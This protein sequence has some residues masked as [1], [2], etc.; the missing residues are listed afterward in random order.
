ME[1]LK[2]HLLLSGTL[3]CVVI[4]LTALSLACN[5]FSVEVSSQVYHVSLKSVS[6]Y[7]Q[8]GDSSPLVS[9][10]FGE[11]Q[12]KMCAEDTEE[13]C[14][15][16]ASFENAGVIYL[17]FCGFAG[18]CLVAGLLHTVLVYSV[19][20]KPFRHLSYFHFTPAPLYIFGVVLYLT[21]SKV[22]STPNSLTEA[23]LKIAYFLLPVTVLEFL[24]VLYVKK[25]KNWNFG[26]LK[27]ETIDEVKKPSE[28]YIEYSLDTEKFPEETNKQLKDLQE[29]LKEETKTSEQLRLELINK[30]KE[31]EESNKQLE[32]AQSSQKVITELKETQTKLQ[33]EL[34]DNKVTAGEV[35]KLKREIEQKNKLFKDTQ[36]KHYAERAAFEQRLKAKDQELA[37]YI[38]LKRTMSQEKSQKS[39]LEQENYEYLEKYQQILAKSKELESELE[40]LKTE[41]TKL[42]ED[43]KAKEAETVQVKE[44]HQKELN[45]LSQKL[46]QEHQTEI[47]ELTRKLEEVQ[48]AETQELQKQLFE[49]ENNLTELSAQLQTLQANYES[50]KQAS[51]K[52]DSSSEDSDSKEQEILELR[53][54]KEDYYQK[55]MEATTENEKL[56]QELETFSNT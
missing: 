28:S 7:Y 55:F 56:K 48:Q 5:F 33:K 20:V 21:V 13:L 45:E 36:E 9:M 42:Q 40:T 38:D 17:L 23:G 3:D 11:F 1:K 43:H 52:S 46:T 51:E 32:D 15:N 29:K 26:V 12:D 41:H 49:K 37:D 27:Y 8:I 31:L 16:L 2:L 34:E 22:H 19:R 4:L 44:T 54:A 30:D 18:V 50:A 39:K 10:S 53:K 14:E 25:Y 6:T 24:Y 35:L 47:T